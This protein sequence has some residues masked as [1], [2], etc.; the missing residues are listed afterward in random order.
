MAGVTRPRDRQFVSVTKD[1]TSGKL[2][3][4]I[5]VE[6][7]A[8]LNA[9]INAVNAVSQNGIVNHKAYTVATVPSASDNAG[10]SIYVTD[11]TGGPTLAFSNGTNWLRYS[12]G[13]TIS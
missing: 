9:L 5:L 1:P 12:D 2:T 3:A 10:R 4:R 8:F 11:E 7:D 13:A 6:W